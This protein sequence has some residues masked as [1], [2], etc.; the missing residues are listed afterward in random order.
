MTTFKEVKA[1]YKKNLGAESKP[2]VIMSLVGEDSNAF[3][4][5]GRFR[6]A[7]RAQ[8]WGTD[9]EI[10]AVLA[11]ARSGDYDHLLRVMV[12]HTESDEEDD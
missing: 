6:R 9:K 7:A 10:D 2:K 8:K 1:E 5:M 11:D 4:I 12:D 3:S